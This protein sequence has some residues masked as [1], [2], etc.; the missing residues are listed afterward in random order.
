MLFRTPACWVSLA[1]NQ[2]SFYSVHALPPKFYEEQKMFAPTRFGMFAS[3]IVT[4]S[5]LAAASL[6]ATDWPSV[7]AEGFV[8]QANA[9]LAATIQNRPDQLA[10]NLAAILDAAAAMDGLT[11]ADLLAIISA[12]YASDKVDPLVLAKAVYPLLDKGHKGA[13]ANAL[14]AAAPANV[15]TEMVTAFTIVELPTVAPRTAAAK[16]ATAVP[17]N[18]KPQVATTPAVDLPPAPEITTTKQARSRRRPVSL[19]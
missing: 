1:P 4:F 19:P 9:S 6:H 5:V 10:Q 2:V 18:L 17:A 8:A 16:R 15:R 11:E 14:V 13:I 12:V 3:F 7:P